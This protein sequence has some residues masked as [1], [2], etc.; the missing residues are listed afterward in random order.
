MENDTV[1]IDSY[2]FDF[3]F[4]RYEK[5][6]MIANKIIIELEKLLSYPKYMVQSLRECLFFSLCRIIN[7]G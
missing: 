5:W 2:V 6:L 7:N 1:L 4:I 3:L